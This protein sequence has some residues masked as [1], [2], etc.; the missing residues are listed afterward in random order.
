MK[1]NIKL[2]KTLTAVEEGRSLSDIISPLK[3]MV[4][5]LS[6]FSVRN[7]QQIEENTKEIALLQAHSLALESEN[8]QADR[9]ADNIAKLLYH[10]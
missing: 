1:F 5:E 3:D 2:P 9:V 8:K 7:G 10:E 6:L 4:H